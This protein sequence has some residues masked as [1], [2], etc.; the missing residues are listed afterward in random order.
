MT[1][2]LVE[3]LPWTKSLFAWLLAIILILLVWALL[4]FPAY[5]LVLFLRQARAKLAAASRVVSTQYL[6]VWRVSG[7]QALSRFNPFFESHSF[8]YVRDQN[9]VLWKQTVAQLVA[10]INALKTIAED[11]SK[12]VSDATRALTAAMTSIGK[13]DTRFPSIPTLPDSTSISDDTGSLSRERANLIIGGVIVLAIVIVNVGMLSQIL[14][15]IVDVGSIKVL[16]E[17]RLYHVFAALLTLVEA[18][19]GVLYGYLGS[20]EGGSSER[21]YIPRVAVVCISVPLAFI[22]G[23]FYS[24]VGSPDERFRSR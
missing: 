18:G 3:Q 16:G 19:V 10:P 22:E 14:K 1:T 13:T 15:D 6:D 20:Q 8:R 24:R 5:L 2:F 7:T 4:S 23:L 9:R 11:S 12:N 17:V 21:T